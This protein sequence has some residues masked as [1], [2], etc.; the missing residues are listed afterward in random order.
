M[1]KERIKSIALVLLIFANI[2]LAGKIL[3]NKKLWLFSY[4]FFVNMKNSKKSAYSLE[5]TLALPD[6]IVVNTGY[7]TSRF[8]YLRNSDGFE[9]INESIES[10]LKKAFSSKSCVQVSE[11]EWYSVLTAKSI[12]IS[13]PCKYSAQIFAGF[14]GTDS[15]EMGFTAFSDIAVGENGNVYVCDDSGYYRIPVI[16]EE[17]S[18]IIRNA[19]AENADEES[20]INY[21][22]DLNFDKEFGDQKTFL[23]PMTLIYSEPIEAAEL[24]VSNPVF[25]PDGAVNNRMIE[26]ILSAFSINPNTVFR[27]TETDGTLVFVE[28]NGILRLSTDGTLD[29]EASGAG[30]K[31]GTLTDGKANVLQAAAFIDNVNRNAGMEIDMCITSDILSD[32]ADDFTFDYMSDGF[33]IKYYGKNAVRV[34]INNG[35]ITE[36]TQIIRKYQPSAHTVFSPMYIETLDDVILKYRNSMNEIHITNMYPAYQDDENSEKIGLNWHIDIEDDIA[37]GQ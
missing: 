5:N 35:C 23:S 30:I 25:K 37:A 7:Q 24:A 22:F 18:P 6:K 29:F 15:T 2:V 1:K 31:A 32:N 27:Y 3:V 12:Y 20:V 16:S 4:N 26:G 33:R 10:V 34:K 17:I 11:N 8:N 9:N 14:L 13:Y 28:N 36:Y 21:S 19:A